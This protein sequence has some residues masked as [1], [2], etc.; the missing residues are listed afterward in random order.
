[1]MRNAELFQTAKVE[2]ERAEEAVALRERLMAILGHDLR[3]PLTSIRMG[4]E[5]LRET[6]LATP[7]ERVANRI[8]SSA[9]RM[10]RMIDQLLDF[11]RIRAGQGFELQLAS[12]DLHAICN[13]VIDELRLGRPDQEIALH[14]DGNGQLVCDPDRIAQVLSNLIG[15]A[16]QHGTQ[17][18][19]SVTL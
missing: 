3:N 16:I 18:P 2:R 13:A 5:I 12:V 10:M 8:Q 1:A 6:K 7:E 11:P 15:N 17:G 9:K 14:V 4:A 19:I